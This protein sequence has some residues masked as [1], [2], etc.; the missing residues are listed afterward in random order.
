MRFHEHGADVTSLEKQIEAVVP[1]I[2]SLRHHLHAHPEIAYEETETASRIVSELRDLPGMEIQ[3]G[4]GGTGVVALIAS[5]KSGPCV[6]L[7]ADMD[8]LPIVEETGAPYASTK[9]GMMHA[10]G[11]DGHVS[12][13]VGAAKVLA[14]TAGQLNGPVKF[15]FQPAEEGRGGAKRVIADGALENP[16]V[17]AVFGFHNWPAPDLEFGEIG[18][19]VGGFM[20][21]SCDF[22]I[23]IVGRGGHAAIPHLAID[24]IRVGAEIVTGVPGFVESENQ[25]DES[26]V[27][28]VAH[29]DAG[30]TVNVIPETAFLEGT[31][32]SLS[33]EQMVRVPERF[34]RF[35][36]TQAR[37]FGASAEVELIPGYPVT[38][39]EAKCTDIVHAIA[40]D[41]FGSD[42]VKLPFPP[43]LAAEDFSFYQEIRPGCFYFIGVR[44][45]ENAAVP[46]LHHPKFDFNDNILPQAIRMHCEIALRFAENWSP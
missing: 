24:P 46:P 11:H 36:E 5:D 19:R 27:I 30:N 4:V 29:F 45:P 41:L 10:C 8:C 12:A 23:R 3:T 35:V 34:A 32:R 21:G 40:T 2:V 39:N 25:K 18:L 22:R 13:L 9:Q 38:T 17:A 14:N 43:V 31:I 42:R 26:L 33:T 7:R 37:K 28:T 16:R 44:P 20:G 15:L 1:E 6:A